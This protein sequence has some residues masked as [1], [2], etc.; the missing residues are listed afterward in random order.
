MTVAAKATV[1]GLAGAALAVKLRS[2]GCQ[3]GTV[4]G[5][6]AGNG[7]TAVQRRER[8]SESVFIG[9]VNFIS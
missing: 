9:A 2:C 6:A 3:Q 1:K 5:L 8:I 4:A 7:M